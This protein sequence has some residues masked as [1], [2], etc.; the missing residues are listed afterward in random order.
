MLTGACFSSCPILSVFAE[1]KEQR[2][3]GCCCCCSAACPAETKVAGLGQEPQVLS[4][5]I[6]MASSDDGGSCGHGAEGAT[7]VWWWCWAGSGW[8][9][10][11]FR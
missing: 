8:W 9:S 4:H 2:C 10:V 3:R 6:V 7:G 11:L 5:C 1:K